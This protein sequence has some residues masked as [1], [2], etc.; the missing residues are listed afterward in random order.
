M[1]SLFILSTLLYVFQVFSKTPFIEDGVRAELFELTDNNIS[2]FNITLPPEEFILFKE[3]ANR[4]HYKGKG[5]NSSNNS[6]EEPGF[7]SDVEIEINNLDN[8]LPRIQKNLLMILNNLKKFNLI[9]MYP[10]LNKNEFPELLISDKGYCNFDIDT[11]YN[12]F[13]FESQAY[14]Y[15]F[16]DINIYDGSYKYDLLVYQSNEK[17]RLLDILIRLANMTHFKNFYEDNSL[18]NELIEY[19]YVT[20][21][22]FNINLD[23]DALKAFE[24]EYYERESNKSEEKEIEEMK[25]MD[26]HIEEVYENLDGIKK[27]L[28]RIIKLLKKN[29]YKSMYPNHDI[30]ELLPELKINENGFSD[31]DIDNIMK[32][33]NFNFEDYITILPFNYE[34]QNLN[35]MVYQSN[36]NFD[37]L[38]ILTT[39]AQVT[40]FT[41]SKKDNEFVRR[42]VYFK[43]IKENDDKTY[44][45]DSSGYDSFCVTYYNENS[46]YSTKKNTNDVLYENYHELLITIIKKTYSDVKKILNLIKKFSFKNKYLNTNFEKEFPELKI[47][48][49]GKSLIDVANIMKGYITDE[50]YYNTFDIG[51]SEEDLEMAIY[52]SNQIF[53]AIEVFGRLAK[54]VTYH[55]SFD[56]DDLIVKL[57]KFKYYSKNEDGSYYFDKSSY[58]EFYYYY[59]SI[60]NSPVN[61]ESITKLLNEQ[62]Q[63]SLKEI[64]SLLKLITRFNLKQMYPKI[65]FNEKLPELKVNDK[66]YSKMKI[67]E[68][69]QGFEFNRK[70]YEYYCKSGTMDQVNIL[71][72][73]QFNPNFNLLKILNYLANETTYNFLLKDNELVK[74]LV[75][76][77]YV[78]VDEDGHISVDYYSYNMFYNDYSKN[79]DLFFMKFSSDSIHDYY[80]YII[81]ITSNILSKLK[82]NNIMELFPNID[83][84]ELPELEV[85]EF[86]YSQVD[87]VRILS[88]FTFN[89]DDYTDFVKEDVITESEKFK[90][91]ALQSNPD[92]DV[93]GIFTKLAEDIPFTGIYPE[94]ELLYELIFFKAIKKNADSYYYDPSYFENI[95]NNRSN[96]FN[97]RVITSEP[98]TEEENHDFK[99][100]NATMSVN[101]NG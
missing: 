38:K 70:E 7:F 48:R 71:I 72:A 61:E 89:R 15:Q 14:Y 62:Y 82:E 6:S 1:K 101:I 87:V 39:L 96:L 4:N 37:I 12:G 21:D 19:V 99:T 41:D 22:E 3:R 25:K 31:I 58:F 46:I 11:V 92:F 67:K 45:L 64:E 2:C 20:K 85:D 60:F 63:S 35:L 80:L 30:K 59:R 56:D 95:R 55:N 42:L 76:Y 66:G 32:G 51:F 84:N 17:F 44:S 83:F 100:K 28:K 73:F 23:E 86:G 34:F 52:Q 57:L 75:Y 5:K 43:F 27:N 50:E 13:E 88:G 10:Q 69:L 49:D 91:I 94:N 98:F 97:S 8:E 81:R 79:N 77:K 47:N 24:D 93:L 18:K 40:T 9:E 53:D 78:D 36:N 29:N 33:F 65:D 54:K 74:A 26:K 68:I 16:L 90:T